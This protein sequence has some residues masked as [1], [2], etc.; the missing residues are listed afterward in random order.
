[1]TTEKQSSYFL[2]T[3]STILNGGNQLNKNINSLRDKDIDK[4]RSSNKKYFSARNKKNKRYISKNK[5]QKSNQNSKKTYV[6]IDLQ[7]VSGA[8][9]IYNTNKKSNINLKN[10][11]NKIPIRKSFNFYQYVTKVNNKEKD[12]EEKNISIQKENKVTNNSND[13]SPFREILSNIKEKNK[14][15]NPIHRNNNNNLK[16]I[17]SY[18]LNT[19]SNRTNTNPNKSK[20]L[21]NNDNNIDKDIFNI[22]NNKDFIPI[23]NC[24]TFNKKQKSKNIY[25]N[26]D[27]NEDEIIN[28]KIE[29]INQIKTITKTNPY[30]FNNNIKNNTEEENCKNYIKNKI[31]NINNINRCY[32]LNYNYNNNNSVYNP[33]PYK[34]FLNSIFEQNY[35]E[36]YL[37]DFNAFSP[38]KKN[39]QFDYDKNKKYFRNKSKGFL[40]IDDDNENKLKKMLENIPRHLKEKNKSDIYCIENKNINNTIK[41]RN[42]NRKLLHYNY[43]TEKNNNN[44]NRKNIFELINHVMPPN[45]LINNKNDELN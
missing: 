20:N 26:A 40:D 11:K 16:E 30:I 45:K 6:G 15:N 8:S 41:D 7:K 31:N 22:N 1:M 34:S 36:K 17:N 13:Y 21:T 2:R 24:N 29:L 4:K 19:H 38:R 10:K 42:K 25:L 35:T 33:L 37:K 44:K 32:S 14:N 39:T 18:L 23:Y 28:K 5:N 43:L 12:E 3:Q 9:H 27:I